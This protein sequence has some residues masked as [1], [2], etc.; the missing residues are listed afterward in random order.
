LLGERLGKGEKLH[1]II[2]QSPKI[3]EGVST[4]KSLYEQCRNLPLDLPIAFAV[5]R[6]L[7]E[8]QMPTVAVK[9]LLSREP[10]SEIHF[11]FTS[12]RLQ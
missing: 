5:Y 12:Q 7:Y 8:N 1:Q 4:A 10:G 6:I 2:S 11:D 3:A 9:E